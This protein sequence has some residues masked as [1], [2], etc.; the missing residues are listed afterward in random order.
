MLSDTCLLYRVWRIDIFPTSISTPLLN[1]LLIPTIASSL[2]GQQEPRLHVF[3]GGSRDEPSYDQLFLLVRGGSRQQQARHRHLP[4]ATFS[5]RGGGCRGEGG[6]VYHPRTGKH[7]APLRVEQ[8]EQRGQSRNTKIARRST[9][10][11]YTVVTLLNISW[12]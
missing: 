1:C 10:V 3:C 2:F 8:G 5:F 12:L 4:N 9:I 6:V 7:V 11:W